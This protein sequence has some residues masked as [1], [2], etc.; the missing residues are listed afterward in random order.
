MAT[1]LW[2]RACA[3]LFAS[4]DFSS[5][6][7]FGFTPFCVLVS[8]KRDLEEALVATTSVEASLGE[9]PLDKPAQTIVH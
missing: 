9:F 5:F 2:G 6:S 1:P 3:A 8:A 7:L 4:S